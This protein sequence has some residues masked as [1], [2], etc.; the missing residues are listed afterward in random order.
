MK[1]A[2]DSLAKKCACQSVVSSSRLV[3]A[4]NSYQRRM[5]ALPDNLEQLVPK[6]FDVIPRD[7]YDGVPI[8]YSKEKEIVYC[9]GKNLQ[10]DGGSTEW[11]DGD[12][13]HCDNRHLFKERDVVF[14]V[15]DGNQSFHW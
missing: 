6:S 12:K 1:P 4:L 7:P 3:L 15:F 13:P 5:G 8:R 10:D 2:A 11:D 9:I 14:F